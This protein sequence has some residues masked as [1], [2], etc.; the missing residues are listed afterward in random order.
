MDNIV[1]AFI[2][3]VD[4]DTVSNKFLFCPK[5]IIISDI[6]KKYRPF[7]IF[8]DVISIKIIFFFCST[9]IIYF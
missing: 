9:K 4:I 6:K 2:Y 1:N 3:F 7:I 5:Q 8:Y